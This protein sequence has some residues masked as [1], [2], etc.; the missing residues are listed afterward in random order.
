[1]SDQPS[2]P[3]ED[4]TKLIADIARSLARQFHPDVDTM[5]VYQEL[6]LKWYLDWRFISKYLEMEDEAKGWALLRKAL[7]NAGAT[8]CQ[9]EKAAVRGYDVNDNYHYSKAVLRELLPFLGDTPSFSSLAVQ[10]E[11]VGRSTKPAHE[12]GDQLALMSDLHNAW[13]RLKQEQ[14]NL[15]WRAYVEPISDEPYKTIGQELG[16]TPEA[17]YMRIDRALAGLQQLLGGP[18]PVDRRRVQSN[19]AAQAQTRSDYGGE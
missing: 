19:A 10:G 5:D 9:A 1:M 6:H 17:C 3:D 12:G 18:R 7:Q 8:Y 4:Q 14:R 16:I 13:P 11:R 15:L 2:P